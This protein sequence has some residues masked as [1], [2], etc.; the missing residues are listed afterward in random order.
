MGSNFFQILINKYFQNQETLFP[1]SKKK[2]KNHTHTH[3]HQSTPKG[4]SL[5]NSKETKDTQSCSKLETFF[6]KT[7]YPPP[8][9]AVLSLL[10]RRDA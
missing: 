7:P 9:T 10:L 6:L 1:I 4:R 3:H 2:K 5:N 8:Q